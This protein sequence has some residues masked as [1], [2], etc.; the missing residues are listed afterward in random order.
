MLIVPKIQLRPDFAAG[1]RVVVRVVIIVIRIKAH[2]LHA[3]VARSGVSAPA[4]Y[5]NP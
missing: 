2:A 4:N 5:G 1:I 3:V